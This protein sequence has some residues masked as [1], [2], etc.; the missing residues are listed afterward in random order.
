MLI[1]ASRLSMSRVS[2][3]TECSVQNLNSE[4]LHNG[5]LGR[6]I[7]FDD[8]GYPVVQFI[9]GGTSAMQPEAFELNNNIGK[10]LATRNQVCRQGSFH[11]SIYSVSTG[12]LDFGMG[13][14]HT[15]SARVDH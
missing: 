10:I 9:S 8:A 5:S 11:Y 13:A 4:G 7:A 12:A 15:Q 3:I 1:K 2:F 6:V 14:E